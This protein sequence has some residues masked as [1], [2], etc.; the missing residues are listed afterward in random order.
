MNKEHLAGQL[1]FA[2][3]V[4]ELAIAAAHFLMPL[5]I[6]RSARIAGV[7][8]EYRSFLSLASIAIGVCLATLGGLSIYFSKRLSRDDRAGRF[9][10]I[11]QGLLWTVR[12][13]FELILPVRIPLF[14]LSNPTTIILPMLVVI[15]LLFLT[16]TLVF[17]REGSKKVFGNAQ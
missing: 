14:F 8:E 1:F 12:V 11:S 9:F 16:S 3:G 10:C 17:Q 13:I 7:A 2:G 15:A 4:T 6:D 5:S